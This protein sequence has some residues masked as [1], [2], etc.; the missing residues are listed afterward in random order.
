MTNSTAPEGEGDGEVTGDRAGRQRI[1][2]VFH[3]SAG[4][5]VLREGRCLALH[6]A[7]GQWVFP[8]GHLEEGEGP[9]DAAI[10]EVREET[11]YTIRILGPIGSTRY[12]F[13]QTQQHRKHVEWFLA[14]VTG[15]SLLL[16]SPISGVEFLD[17]ATAQA[18]LTHGNDRDI[19]QSAFALAREL[20]R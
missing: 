18:Q 15:G 17:L 20:G 9:A 12:A 7:D 4:A 13:G 16:E 5:V 14:E 19:A 6:L 8:K 11:G 2:Q 3:Q 1:A 10:R